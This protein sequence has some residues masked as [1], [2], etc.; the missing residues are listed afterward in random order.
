MVEIAIPDGLELF[1]GRAP[2]AD[3]RGVEYDV[4][5]ADWKRVE[6]EVG[7]PQ[8]LSRVDPYYYK[9]F[10][11]AGRMLKGARDLAV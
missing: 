5:A 6:R 3:A 4:E 7:T 11:M 8:F 9:V 10:I 2:R 1:S